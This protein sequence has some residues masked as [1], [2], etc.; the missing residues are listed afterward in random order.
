MYFI[1]MTHRM[2]L[3]ITQIFLNGCVKRMLI[4]TGGIA[5][6]IVMILMQVLIQVLQKFAMTE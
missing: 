3:R 1:F 6:L 4:L 5:V 2:I